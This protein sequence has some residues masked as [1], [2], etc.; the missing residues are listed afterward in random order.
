MRC[1]HESFWRCADCTPTFGSSKVIFHAQKI[2]YIW[3]DSICDGSNSARHYQTIMLQ[4]SPCFDTRYVTAQHP[5]KQI[6][7]QNGLHNMKEANMKPRICK[8]AWKPVCVLLVLLMPLIW[9]VAIPSAS[10]QKITKKI[11]YA[12]SSH[13]FYPIS[14]VD[15]LVFDNLLLYL[16]NLLNVIMPSIHF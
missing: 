10:S 16:A 11:D 2:Q 8:T 3:I 1:A 14:L 15:I 12:L 7:K 5:S 13:R 4:R 9:L 6:A